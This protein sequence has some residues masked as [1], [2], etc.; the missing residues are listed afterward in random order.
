[1]GVPFNSKVHVPGPVIFDPILVITNDPW[2]SGV[3][4]ADSDKTGVDACAATDKWTTGLSART[5]VKNNA[6]RE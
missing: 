4:L 1:M 3:Q 6:R 5:R 2:A